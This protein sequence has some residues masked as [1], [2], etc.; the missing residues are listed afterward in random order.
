MSGIRLR[1]NGKLYL[2][3]EDFAVKPS[4][5][6]TN[7]EGKISK[8]DCDIVFKYKSDYSNFEEII[9]LIKDATTFS[10]KSL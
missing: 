10:T 9:G 8:E 7:Y 3:K 5:N 2:E 6:S 1:F 4:T